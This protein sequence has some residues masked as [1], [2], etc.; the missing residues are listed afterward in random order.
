M[1]SVADFLEVS[2]VFIGLVLR[3]FL[4]FEVHI[5]NSF[6][7]VRKSLRNMCIDDSRISGFFVGIFGLRILALNTYHIGYILTHS[8]KAEP[9]GCVDVFKLGSLEL[10]LVARSIRYILKENIGLIHRHCE[11]IIFHEMARRLRI[12]NLRVGKTDNAFGIVFMGIFGKSLV[13]CKI[14]TC[15]GIL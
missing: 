13:A 15:I 2:G 7:S 10:S 9:S 12:E 3:E 14:Y 6:V 1:L 11:L 8:Q 5:E 4:C